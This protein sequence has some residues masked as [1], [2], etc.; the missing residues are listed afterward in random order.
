[1]GPFDLPSIVQNPGFSYVVILIH[2]TK[3]KRCSQNYT[4]SRKQE[5]KKGVHSLHTV[6][7]Y[8]SAGCVRP[9]MRLAGSS[10]AVTPPTVRVASRQQHR[11][12]IT[13]LGRQPKA[14][15]QLPCANKPELHVA[16]Y[17][18]ES[19]PLRCLD[20]LTPDS[21]AAFCWF[22]FGP[23]CTS[24]I[25]LYCPVRPSTNEHGAAQCTS[26]PHSTCPG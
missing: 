16:S 23:P 4:R 22:R 7:V 1:M 11:P 21:V 26:W 15:L 6:H 9:H 13:Q 2:C 5:E 24:E 18:R 25:Y 10:T 19:K 12:Y 20:N 17:T 3:G 8:V 14:T